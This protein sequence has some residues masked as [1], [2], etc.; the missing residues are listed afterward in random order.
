MLTALVVAGRV[1]LL[2]VLAGWLVWA[3]QAQGIV[4]FVQRQKLL[5]D[6][7][8]HSPWRAKEPGGVGRSQEDPGEPGELN[9]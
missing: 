5:P 6:S 7:L 4:L 8:S 2:F 1:V 3:E 9:A